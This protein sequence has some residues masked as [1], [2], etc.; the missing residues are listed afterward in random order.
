MPTK[1]KAIDEVPTT[2]GD[3]PGDQDTI[4]SF[5]KDPGMRGT[6]G[7]VHQPWPV[8]RDRAVTCSNC[9]WSYEVRR[10]DDGSIAVW[11]WYRSR[12]KAV[13]W[14]VLSGVTTKPKSKARASDS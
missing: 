7:C 9:G 5:P 13:V 14:S 4:D 8:V 11:A 12:S 6:S 1:R 2:E 3:E 10:A